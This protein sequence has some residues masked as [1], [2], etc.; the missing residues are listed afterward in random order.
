MV[1]KR[2]LQGIVGMAAF[3]MAAGAGIAAGNCYSVS[4]QEN[5]QYSYEDSN[6]DGA[7][8]YIP[9]DNTDVELYHDNT[10]LLRTVPTESKYTTPNLPAVRNQNPYGTCWAF[11][12]VACV[13]INLIN[14]GYVTSDIDLSEMH[15]A[16]FTYHSVVDPLGGTDGD[17][18]D[19]VAQGNSFLAY[20]GNYEY[21]TTSL[22]KWSGL[23][24]ESKYPYNTALTSQDRVQEKAY[25]DV[26]KVLSVKSVDMKDTSQVKAA[27]KEYGAVGI[28]YY[29][30]NLYYNRNDNKYSYY[31][32]D[33]S[34]ANNH[35]V[36]IVGWDDTYSK[37]NF[38]SESDS[39][40]I[41][42]G[43]GA[44][45]VRNSWGD[46]WG[47]QGY[48]HLSYYDKTLTDIGYLFDATYNGKADYY[49]NNYQYSGTILRGYSYLNSG[50]TIA[51]V[52]ETKANAGGAEELKAVSF[53]TK[54]AAVNYDVKIYTG[55]TDM[56]DPTRGTLAGEKKGTTSGA[57]DYTV[58][59]DSPIYMEENTK[60]SVV[61]T[62]SKDDG[63]AVLMCLD[64]SE[65]YVEGAWIKCDSK[66]LS[67]QSYMK[68]Y[69]MAPDYD[70]W[71]Y[72][73]TG[74][75]N[76]IIRSYTSN[77]EKKVT[78]K[79]EPTPTPKPEPTPTPKPEPTPTPTPEPT[80]TPTPTPTPEPTP[81]PTPEPT[82]EPTPAPAANPEWIFDG[83]GWWYRHSDGSYTT[84]GWEYINGTWYYFTGSGYMSTGWIEVNGTWYYMNSDGAML[85]GWV[86]VNGTWYYMN[87]DGAMLTGWVDV[88][89]TWYYMNGSGAML[90][91]WVNVNGTWY[92]MNSSGAMLTGWVDVRGTWYY[93]YS[94]GAMAY[95]TYIG[96]YYVD[97]SGAW[98]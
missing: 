49:D 15:L 24:S 87:S 44:W 60:Y 2:L 69:N 36:T 91:D 97:D 32:N 45:I 48:F 37:N 89:G 92:Y 41:P 68:G 1:R 55:L 5:N 93:M 76:W 96:S 27:I 80:P 20:G 4:A 51:N 77:V 23:A 18:T 19:T 53:A 47:E 57:G 22:M 26:A 33:S 78:P 46:Y 56:S 62:L 83:T 16:Y 11:S 6:S 34:K 8:G 58:T 71:D 85:T 61:I 17:E 21:A 43:D 94:S 40:T 67:N 73:K 82:P 84:N 64:G 50:M 75:K 72:G 29:D 3:V 79:P 66:A 90:T 42:Q 70:W 35:A 12:T 74:D 52:F 39:S 98:V 95:N 7:H 81:T 28:S 9:P 38:G 88:N 31:C 30:D 63:T 25:D 86:D 54:S 13:E 59:L 14:K 10:A 65:K